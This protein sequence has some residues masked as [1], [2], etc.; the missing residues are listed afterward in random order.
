MSSFKASSVTAF[1]LP[2][3]R[4]PELPLI[5][6]DT[7]LAHLLGIKVRTLW[8]LVYACRE[9]AG[10][11]DSCYGH[12][13]IKKNG[14]AG[15]R[16][17][18]R[19]VFVMSDRLAA[20]QK[21]II[22][23]IIRKIP[24]GPQVLAYE[25]GSSTITASA[26][27]SGSKTLIKLD[28][29]DFFPTIRRSWIQHYFMSLGY[30]NFVS[31][32]L[33]QLSCV[34]K[35]QSF[36]KEKHKI[37][38]LPQGNAIA[39]FIS[40]RVAEEKLDKPAMARLAALSPNLEY[41]RYSDNLYI[42]SRVKTTV[43]FCD[44]VIRQVAEEVRKAG[45]IPHKIRK[46]PYWKKQTMLGTVVNEKPNLDKKTY[47]L[48]RAVLYNC[49][50]KDLLA[51][52]AAYGQRTNQSFDSLDKFVMHLQGKVTWYCR[53]LNDTRK[54][55]FKTWLAIIKDRA[56]N[57]SEDAVWEAVGSSSNPS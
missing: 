35:M 40:N 33:S 29:R 47:K 46:V 24:T 12:F 7:S 54:A 55:Q 14:S 48:F 16:G 42:T 57:M 4:H 50:Y 8:Y 17:K 44:E 6:D 21:E 9:L 10:S 18:T 30:N 56:S 3:L 28:C 20:V 22:A 43:E 37:Y 53:I 32:L 52:C 38:I 5:F 23:R 49:A 19:E 11:A 51:E 13:T 34:G 45:W 2:S 15:K 41:Y 1:T 36:G 39:P 31:S 26:K 27:C 25:A